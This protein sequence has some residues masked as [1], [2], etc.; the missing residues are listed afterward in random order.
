LKKI[1]WNFKKKMF[2]LTY[3]NPSLVN[4]KN[5]NR[6]S[7]FDLNLSN[8]CDRNLV[9]QSLVLGQSAKKGKKFSVVI[10]CK[11]I[12]DLLLETNCVWKFVRVA[13]PDKEQKMSQAKVT[14]LLRLLPRIRRPTTSLWADDVIPI[15]L[16][17]LMKQF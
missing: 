15:N 7:K 16:E 6:I 1:I 4:S 9:G 12:L 11:Q 17:G 13:R 3:F 2:S 14:W 5:N 8:K 10:I